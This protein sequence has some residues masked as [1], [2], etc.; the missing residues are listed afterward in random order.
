MLLRLTDVEL[1]SGQMMGDEGTHPC[2]D[3]LFFFLSFM[4]V[5][6][7]GE[8]RIQRNPKSIHLFKFKV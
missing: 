4:Y 2:S 1:S 7:K 8:P 5:C 3:S 6:D